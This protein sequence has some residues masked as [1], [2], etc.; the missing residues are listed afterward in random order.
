MQTA[1]VIVDSHLRIDGN[2]LGVD[3]VEDILDELTI[4]NTAKHIAQR[5]KRYG[6]WDMPDNF[7][8]ANL[9]G[10]E[11]VMPRGY[12]MQLKRILVENDIKVVWLD[13]RKGDLGKPFR[14]S[15]EFTPRPHQPLAVRKMRR[16]Q[17][18]IYQAPTGSG[19]SLT[20]ISFIHDVSPL[21]TIVLVDQVGLQS[22]WLKEFGN[23]L[24]EKNVGQI[25]SG[26]WVDDKRI[27][28]ATVQTIWSKIKRGELPDDFFDLYDCVIVDECHHVSAETVEYIVGMFRAKWRIGVSA[29]PNRLDH[30]FAIVRAVLGEVF[31]QD[32]E[33]R[34]RKL[35]VLVKPQ[36]RVVKTDFKF[37]YM[38]DH[39]SDNKGRCRKRGCTIHRQQ[40]HRNN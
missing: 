4:D 29:T 20:C 19:K 25:G 32:D 36:V 8:L 9:D 1:R 30:K 40:G 31:H 5:K 37:E 14:W 38:T 18:G 17:Q 39:E 2:V 6:W 35:G 24:D 22:Q 12:A 11:L 7:L 28:V 34:L 26:V 15:K 16:H 33:D 21:K 13:R 23:W 10:D 27:T 3:L